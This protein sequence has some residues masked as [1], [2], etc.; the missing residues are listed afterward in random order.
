MLW[1]VLAWLQAV[2]V[3]V[4]VSNWVCRRGCAWKQPSCI[5]FRGRRSNDQHPQT[6]TP[7]AHRW[8]NNRACMSASVCVFVCECMCVSFPSLEWDHLTRVTH[9][10]KHTPFSWFADTHRETIWILALNISLPRFLSQVSC[11]GLGLRIHLAARS[12]AQWRNCCQNTVTCCGVSQETLA[13]R[14]TPQKLWTLP[15]PQAASLALSK[16]QW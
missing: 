1:M 8:S 16:I 3:C 14:T 2:G 4:Y 9:T 11:L 7:E 5:L 15:I 12:S 10:H 6:A 13:R